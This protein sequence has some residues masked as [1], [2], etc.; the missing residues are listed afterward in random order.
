MKLTKFTFATLICLFFFANTIHSQTM[1][2]TYNIPMFSHSDSFSINLTSQRSESSQ[3]EVVTIEVLNSAGEVQSTISKSKIENMLT[4]AKE[5][6]K[7]MPRDES[8]YKLIKQNDQVIKSLE[9]L[10]NW[11]S[12]GKKVKSFF[13]KLAEMKATRSSSNWSHLIQTIRNVSISTNGNLNW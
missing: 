12:D 2:I 9:N 4:A 13:D 10:N 7:S 11:L 6:Q 3:E 1:N 5:Y 8:N